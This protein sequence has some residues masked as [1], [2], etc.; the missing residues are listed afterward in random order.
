MYYNYE[1]I[2]DNICVHDSHKMN[3]ETIKAK[4]LFLIVHHTK[5]ER[6]VNE[7]A[8][9]IISENYDYIGIF[10]EMALIWKKAIEKFNDNKKDIEIEITKIELMQMG[11][12]IAMYSKL[13]LDEKIFLVS[14]DEFFTVVANDILRIIEGTGTFTVEDWIKFKKGYEFNYNGRDSIVVI[15]KDGIYLGYLSDL[16]KFS[17]LYDLFKINNE[18]FDGKAFIEIWKEV[19]KFISGR[20]WK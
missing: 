14:D 15:K 3:F 16:R 4:R 17:S 1:W 5:D 19:K 11:Y 6:Q 20:S 8:Q 2:N 18:I 10:G 7:A 9:K 13:Y 12:D